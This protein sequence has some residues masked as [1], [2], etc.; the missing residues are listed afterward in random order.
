MAVTQ[1][2]LSDSELQNMSRLSIS[3]QRNSSSCEA[4]QEMEKTGRTDDRP[5]PNKAHHSEFPTWRL[6]LILGSLWIGG[7]FVALGKSST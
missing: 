3:T 1:P 6:V 5:L 7:L 2:N 4:G